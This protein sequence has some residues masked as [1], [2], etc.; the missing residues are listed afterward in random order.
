[1]YLGVSWYINAENI[2]KSSL[3]KAKNSVQNATRNSFWF[4]TMADC[5]IG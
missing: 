1:M 5:L 2:R 4:L 3:Y